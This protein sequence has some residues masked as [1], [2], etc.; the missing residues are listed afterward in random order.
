MIIAKQTDKYPYDQSKGM[1]WK[2]IVNDYNDVWYVNTDMMYDT[3]S[4]REA[5][6]EAVNESY[7]GDVDYTDIIFESEIPDQLVSKRDFIMALC[8]HYKTYP[9]DNS[10]CNYND[11][12]FSIMEIIRILNGINTK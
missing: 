9:G 12:W 10:G 8:K 1:H 2:L 3:E 11:N 6:A 5:I 4:A 7:D